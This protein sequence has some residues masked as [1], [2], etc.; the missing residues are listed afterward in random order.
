MKTLSRLPLV[1]TLL[2]LA[3]IPA[4]S[5]AQAT[6][7]AAGGPTMIFNPATP[8]AEKQ[9]SLNDN[10]EGDVTYQVGKDVVDVTVVPNSKS[11]FPGV[12]ITPPT[13]WNASGFGHVETR[14]TN[15]GTKNIRANLVLYNEGTWQQKHS[16][17]N[18]VTVK[19]GQTI[20]LP[21]IFNY[22]YNQGSY[23]L[24]TSKLVSAL[25]FIGKSDVE[26]KFSFT[27]LV[28]AGPLGEKPFIPTAPVNPANAANK[29]K[30]GILL[31]GPIVLDPKQIVAKTGKA[32][33][34]DDKKS[35]LVDF[36][37]KDQTIALKPI[38]G[39]WNL[40]TYLQV[41]V[42]VINT[43]K[44]PLIFDAMLNSLNGKSDPIRNEKPIPPGAEGE[45]IIPFQ[46]GTPMVLEDDPAQHVLEGK[47]DWIGGLPGTGTTYKSNVTT[48]ITLLSDKDA[49]P[50]TFKVTSIYADIPVL[51]KPDWLGKRPPVSGDWAQTLNEDFNGNMLDLHRWNIYSLDQW[52]IGAQTH[53]SKDNMIVKDGKLS[54]RLEAKRGHQN[55]DPN[56]LVNDYQTGYADTYGKWT[57]RYGYFEA[58]MKFPTAPNTFFAFWMM[59]DRGQATGLNINARQSTKN[60]GM[61]FDIMEALA[62]WGPYRHDFG[63]HWD[64][65]VKYHK[66]NGAFTQYVTPDKDGFVTVGML[67]EPGKVTFY[68]NGVETGSWTSPRVS[69]VQEAFILDMATGG[70]EADPMED[71]QLPSDFVFDYVRVWQR[72]DLA[73][74]EDGPKP[75]D[76]SGHFPLT[77]AEAKAHP[78]M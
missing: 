50:A 55:D 36:S 43:G 9:L 67:W 1:A 38:L 73:S 53:Y 27:G 16:S 58:R 17:A 45:V 29:P 8:G 48:D 19:P 20:T 30:D 40:N 32:S 64:D 75:N 22:S 70:W 5:L 42:K 66:D 11:G 65:Y 6:G 28:A 71:K 68:D 2:A 23:E 69:S 31:G 39:R 77:P 24:D 10:S 35:L 54:M 15:N 37:G 44:T 72:K 60:A 57:Q 33:L 56:L 62:I 7:V 78:I 61:E 13:P 46:A 74:P 63:M 76:G 52:H 47:K 21:T 34:S 25:I 4:I 26:Q 41:H 12:K 59:P 3:A 49:E 14:I 18:I 51:K